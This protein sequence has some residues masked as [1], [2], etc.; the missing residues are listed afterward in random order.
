MA[1]GLITDQDG[2]IWSTTTKKLLKL[3]TATIAAAGNLMV[4]D[5]L[6]KAALK[7]ADQVLDHLRER[8]YTEAFNLICYDQAR[9][10]LWTRD[11]DGMTLDHEFWAAE[12]VGAQISAGA[13]MMATAPANLDEALALC[14]QVMTVTTA[15]NARCG[16]R[17]HWFRCEPI[18][19]VTRKARDPSMDF[20]G[21]VQAFNVKSGWGKIRVGKRSFDFHVEQFVANGRSKTDP[22]A[23]MKVAVDFSSTGDVLTV[24]PRRT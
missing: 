11:H 3:Q 1:D 17:I 4:L 7:T 5:D 13:F 23:R 14:Q 18:R 16:G 19:E 9:D 21:T 12:G 2:H 20:L 24:R 22:K 8:E 6:E 10:R 15:R